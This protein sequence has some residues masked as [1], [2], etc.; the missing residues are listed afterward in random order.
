MTKLYD[1]CP[2]CGADHLRRDTYRTADSWV[3]WQDTDGVWYGGPAH[4][5]TKIT[6]ACGW[7]QEVVRKRGKIISNILRN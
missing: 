2:R 4:E 3:S 5:S 1:T 6:C 7:N